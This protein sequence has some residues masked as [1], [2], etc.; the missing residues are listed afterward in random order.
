MSFTL[1][2]SSFRRKQLYH[3][4]QQAYANGALRLVK[5]LHALLALSGFHP[6]DAMPVLLTQ[7]GL[8][9]LCKIVL[10]QDERFTLAST[11]FCHQK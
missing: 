10:R 6:P 11:T 1:H 7:R 9:Q 4:L 3:R 2:L 5:R 8:Q